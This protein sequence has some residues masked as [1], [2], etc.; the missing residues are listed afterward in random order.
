VDRIVGKGLAGSRILI[1]GIAYKKNVDDMRESPSLKLIELIESRGAHVDYYDPFIPTIP[2]TREHAA[3]TGRKSVKLDVKTVESYDAILI[4]T[5]HDDV[6]YGLMVKH[7]KL[8][9]DTRNSIT[10]AG[11]SGSHV[12]KA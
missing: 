5:D 1:S 12:V 11:F 7:A 4:A 9:V 6:D 2:P 3:L 10:K 8:I